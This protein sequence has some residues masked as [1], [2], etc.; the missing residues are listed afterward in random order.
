MRTKAKMEYFG[1]TSLVEHIKA[2]EA[3]PALT[4]EL[5]ALIQTDRPAAL[6]IHAGAVPRVTE[7]LRDVRALAERE[8]AFNQT[9]AQG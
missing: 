8:N 3:L 2:L 1:T 5:L 9:P 7:L 4:L 6:A